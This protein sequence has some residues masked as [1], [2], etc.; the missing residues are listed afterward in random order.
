MKPELKSRVQECVRFLTKNLDINNRRDL[1]DNPEDERK[2]FLENILGMTMYLYEFNFYP[3]K[4]P[5]NCCEVAFFTSLNGNRW[6]I[7]DNERISLENM[8]KTMIKHCQGSCFGIT[9]YAV[10]ITDNWDDNAVDFWRHNFEKMKTDGIEIEVYFLIG[11]GFV[12]KML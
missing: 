1:I 6:N 11:N 8:F 9:K 7:H 4:Y 3:S 10:I 2:G 12:S 5:S